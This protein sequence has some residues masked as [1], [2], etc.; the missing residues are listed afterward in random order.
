[1]QQSLAGPSSGIYSTAIGW[2]FG[3]TLAL[4]AARM[5]AEYEDRYAK[6]KFAEDDPR[7]PHSFQNYDGLEK[8]GEGPSCFCYRAVRRNDKQAVRLKILR[9]RVARLS[10]IGRQLEELDLY[11]RTY[12]QAECVLSYNHWGRH[13]DNYY[14]EYDFVEGISLRDLFDETPPFHPDLVAG[15][16]LLLIEALEDVHGVRPAQ[17]IADITPQHRNLTPENILITSSGK[18]V[19]T[20]VG[21]NRLTKFAEL[22]GLELPHDPLCFESSELLTRDYADRR[23]DIFSLGMVLMEAACRKLPF[24]GPSIH[25]TRQNIRRNIGGRTRDFYPQSVR[26]ERRRLT[27]SL[28]PIIETMIQHEPERR[29]QQLIEVESRLLKYLEGSHYDD[30]AARL[31]RFL[32]TRTFSEERTRYPGWLSLLFGR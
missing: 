15:L 13:D 31:A 18:L 10:R 20:D 14:L 23:S 32:E 27:R 12:S 29:Y 9:K 16:G 5:T 7:I 28:A 17:E 30:F 2:R 19:L 1:M 6:A 21:F 4:K 8:L 25:R 11:Q 3:R 26:K 22:Q 24:V